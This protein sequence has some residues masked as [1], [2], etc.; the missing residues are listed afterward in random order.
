MK[1]EICNFSSPHFYRNEGFRKSET[2]YRHEP[3][4][5]V[6]VDA[7]STSELEVLPRLTFQLVGESVSLRLHKKGHLI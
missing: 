5:S 6:K 2:S 3:P 1:D 7:G 4:Y